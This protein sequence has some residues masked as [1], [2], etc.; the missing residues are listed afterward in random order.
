M[1]AYRVRVSPGSQKAAGSFSRFFS[2]DGKKEKF[3][4]FA[5]VFLPV[6]YPTQEF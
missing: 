2:I 3:Q 6:V 1:G 4:K 5:Q